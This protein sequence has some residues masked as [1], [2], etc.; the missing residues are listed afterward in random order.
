MQLT[1]NPENFFLLEQVLEQSQSVFFIFDIEP[2]KFRYISP[3]FNEIWDV[4]RNEYYVSPEKLLATIHPDDLPEL[5]LKWDLALYRDKLVQEFRI[6]CPNEKV[7]WL[8]LK[9]VNILTEG[10]QW[11]V[12]GFVE[13]I[14]A[15]RDHDYTLQKYAAK[16]NSSLEI[17]SHDL[18]GPLSIIHRLTDFLLEATQ[19]FSNQDIKGDLQLIQQTCTR[20]V[21]LIRD[22]VNQEFLESVNADLKIE[23]FDL[24]EKIGT[25]VD[26]Y[27]QSERAIVKNFNL[28][29]TNDPIFIEMDEVKFMQVINNLISNAIKFTPE[30]GVI[31]VFIAE[32][33]DQILISVE[34]N[35]IG[36]PK[37]LHPV[38]FDR[39]T[40]A[41]RP[42]LRGEAPVGLG[43]SIIKRIVEMHQGRIWFESTENQGTDFHLAIPKR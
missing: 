17:L 2:K 28:A 29:Y 10:D 14:T 35:G 32:E 40:A 12:A 22:L 6:L 11:A 38:L 34:D 30:H 16:K 25:I 20:S 39:F 33:K 37:E 1:T 26:N 18:A 8:R 15:A 4:D 41:R 19:P 3:V 24:V 23:R 36:I 31:N 13:D 7:K 9:P 42:G 27:R 5:K 43:L 21:T